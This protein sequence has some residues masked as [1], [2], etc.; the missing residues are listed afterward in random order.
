M[1]HLKT[2][3]SFLNEAVNTMGVKAKKFSQMVDNYVDSFADAQAKEK[4]EGGELPDDYMA[5]IKNLGIRLDKAMI[6][7]SATV[8]DRNKILD[9]A[10]KS[11]LK[12]AEV[13]D[14][15]TGDSAIVFDMNQ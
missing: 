1:K 12:Y 14:S 5:A 11:G 2:F 4:E 7:F 10:K 3:E 9:A 13:E 15:E 8:G 6:C